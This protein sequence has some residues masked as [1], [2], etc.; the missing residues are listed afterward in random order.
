MPNVYLYWM[1]LSAIQSYLPPSSATPKAP[2]G[3]FLPGMA[4]R[5]AYVPGTVWGTASS[6]PPS[7]DLG[8]V[9]ALIPP[10]YY[11]PLGSEVSPR[12]IARTTTSTAEGRASAQNR[13]LG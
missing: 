11:A 6:K 9:L 5:A 3:L 4:D 1:S 10:N 7:S 12:P 2:R 8:A 13:Q